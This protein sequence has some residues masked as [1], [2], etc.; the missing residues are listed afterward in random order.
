MDAATPI[1]VALRLA[2]TPVSQNDTDIAGHAM[3]AGASLVTSNMREFTRVR[4]LML[5]DR[6]R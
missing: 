1:K 5:E 2:G 6:L 4:G 3:A